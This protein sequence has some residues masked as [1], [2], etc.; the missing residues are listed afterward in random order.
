MAV[1]V[2]TQNGW[3]A[4]LINRSEPLDPI[5]PPLLDELTLA[6]FQDSM[7]SGKFTAPSGSIR[8]HSVPGPERVKKKGLP[9]PIV[10][11]SLKCRGDWIRTSDLLNPIQEVRRVNSAENTFLSRLTA[12]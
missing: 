8:A 12:F 1:E 6:V 10:T 2:L 5:K 3:T 4:D 7:K 11:T 9:Q